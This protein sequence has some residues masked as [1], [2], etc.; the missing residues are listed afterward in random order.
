MNIMLICDEYCGKIEGLMF[1]SSSRYQ[2]Y[3]VLN[4]SS[5]S[6]WLDLRKYNTTEEDIRKQ[7]RKLKTNARDGSCVTWFWIDMTED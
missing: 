3:V 2:A 4:N 5:D 1:K 7:M 6:F